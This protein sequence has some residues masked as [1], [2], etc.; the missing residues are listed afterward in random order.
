MSL[1]TAFE[2][3]KVLFKDK[4]DALMVFDL[5]STASEYLK[6]KLRKEKLFA[7]P[8]NLWV[9]GRTGAGKTSLGNSFLDSKKMPSS[10]KIDC[11]NFVGR[12]RLESNLIIYDVP[13]QA[14]NG[15]YENIN[16]AALLM[17]QIED[18]YAEPPAV[19]MQD[20]DEF[21]VKDFTDCAS[22]EDEPYV[23]NVT[24][25]QW[26]S[27]EQ[28]KDVGPDLIVFVHAP[29][30]QFL[31]PADGRYL[32]QLL[33]SW[34]ERRKP[35]MVIPALNIFERDGHI[36]P[37]PQN[38]ED[39]RNKITKIYQKVYKNEWFP[40]I[41]EINSLKGERIDRLTDQI[42]QILPQE[43]IE[44]MQQVLKDELKQH[45][46]KEQVNRYY[47]TLSLIAGRLARYTSDKKLEGQNLFQVAAS[48]ISHYGAMTFK[49]PDAIDDIKAQMD[50]LV[51]EVE[52]VEK[53]RQENI[54][55]TENIM[56]EKEITKIVPKIEQKTVTDT[57]YRPVTKKEKKTET[58]VVQDVKM[59]TRTEETYVNVPK[60][61]YVDHGGLGIKDFFFGQKKEKY[62]G[63]EKR[64]IERDE[65]VIISKPQEIERYE[66]TIDW[67][68]EK[69]DRVEDRI[70]GFDTKV[71][72][73]VQVVVGQ[74]DKVVGTKYLKG[75]YPLIE[76]IVGLGLG[77]QHFCYAD[78]PDL[79]IS[80]QQGNLLVEQKLS[81]LKSKIEQLVE[82]PDGEPELIQLLENA[83][84]QEN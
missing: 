75:G 16:R 13:G 83:L 44:K 15:S 25:G 78:S 47:H 26:Q 28:Q 8:I 64:T 48:A 58:T 34:K 45:A 41:V 33:Q 20:T 69:K 3:L 52:R 61:R 10:G 71:V 39:A 19:I 62:I 84:V 66:T 30:K 31:N 59:V 50:A 68:E 23:V 24:V 54:T 4:P 9:T 37:T 49:G 32:E 79:S 38:M 43:K 81:K 53:S 18:E 1:E 56:G 74:V 36:L 70:V 76:F 55:E 2:S 29:D 65:P 51:K 42:C 35:C 22:Q 67:V 5:E 60:T 6:G 82:E 12:I 21:V 77:V 7:S 40:P 11:T 63:Q 46:E 72:E 80:M 17:P 57:T 73:I 27:P 14:S